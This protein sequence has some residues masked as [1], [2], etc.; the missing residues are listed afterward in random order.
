MGFKPSFIGLIMSYVSSA[1]FSVLVNGSP[2]G[3]IIPT[4]GLRLEDPISSYLFII[5]T[6]GLISLLDSLNQELCILGIKVCRGALSINHL[7]FAD[8]SVLFCK[9]YA[10]TNQKIQQ[11]LKV[12]ELAFG[13]HINT[14]KV[15]M[16]FSKNTHNDI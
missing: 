4:R 10:G 15:A 13:W 7:L 16:V 14:T 6:K 11:L 3:H 5:C 8:D 1:S 2:K 12:Y 9:V